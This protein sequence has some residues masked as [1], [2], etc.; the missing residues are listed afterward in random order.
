MV[1][2]GQQ[3]VDVGRG[4]PRQVGDEEGD[5]VWRDV[6]ENGSHGADAAQDLA[7]KAWGKK[8]E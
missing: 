8:R 7:V 1:D 4:V 5:K 6:F 3:S 2:L